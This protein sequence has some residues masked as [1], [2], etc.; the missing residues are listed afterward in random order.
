MADYLNKESGML[1][2][3]GVSSDMR[4][5]YDAAGKGNKR[6]QL[7]LKMYTYR[8]KKYI[9]SYA[10]AMGG[11][12]AVIFTAGVGENQAQVREKSVE[13]LEFLG[14]KLDKEKNLGVH[15]TETVISTPDSRVKVAV[16]PTDEEI[17]IARDTKE[18][19][20]GL[21]K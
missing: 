10:A 5:V 1:G 3:S 6:A 11:I 8:I 18:L 4:D 2:I 7:A 21:K 20:E 13:G 9:G 14:I 15:G 16:I 19:V 17:V 12:D